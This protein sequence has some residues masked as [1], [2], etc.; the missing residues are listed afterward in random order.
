MFK[1]CTFK[2]INT[3]TGHWVNFQF[4]SKHVAVLFS[5]WECLIVLLS[6]IYEGITLFAST[7]V[8]F[9][10]IYYSLLNFNLLALRSEYH[11]FRVSPWNSGMSGM[12]CSVLVGEQSLIARFMGPTWGPPGA[13]RTQVGPM[14]DPWTLLSEILCHPCWCPGFSCH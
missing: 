1:D 11:G 4:Y 7:C 5:F 12:S 9:C 2:I 3:T 8:L 13:D 14:L 10:S 6:A